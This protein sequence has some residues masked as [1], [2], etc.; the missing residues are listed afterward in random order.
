MRTPYAHRQHCGCWRVLFRSER[1]GFADL[2]GLAAGPG[3]LRPGR[4]P[5]AW[6]H[7]GAMLERSLLPGVGGPR[8]HGPR[9]RICR[10]LARSEALPRPA[11]YRHSII[12]HR[13]KGR[14]R[15]PGASA[16]ACRLA[17]PWAGPWAGRTDWHP[18]L[19][20]SPRSNECT[21]PPRRAVRCAPH[22]KRV[23]PAVSAVL[24]NSPGG[25][26]HEEVW[27]GERRREPRVYFE[28]EKGGFFT[29]LVPTP[30]RYT[31]Q[32]IERGRTCI[33]WKHI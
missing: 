25:L 2:A 14:L 24:V 6:S 20:A 4:G 13:N 11:P 18:A 5:A 15:R 16:S 7:A 30:D 21:L 19:F 32:C 29:K 31:P 8:A 23:F 3:C 17:G 28:T 10:S 9:G 33:S 12:L 27:L 26:H 22:R 1:E